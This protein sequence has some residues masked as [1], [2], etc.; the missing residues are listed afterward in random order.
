ME[1]MPVDTNS[2]E[3]WEWAIRNPSESGLTEK[4]IHAMRE[5]LDLSSPDY[6]RKVLK[7]P[8]KYGFA[9]AHATELAK[10]F[11]KPRR[12]TNYSS[13]D[14]YWF[15]LQCKSDDKKKELEK[16]ELMPEPLPSEALAKAHHLSVLRGEL[17]ELEAQLCGPYQAPPVADTAPEQPAPVEAASD[18]A[19]I[20]NWKMKIQTE[21]T[22]HC[23]R[24]RQSGA[25]PTKKSIVDSMANWC[26]KNDV[27]TDSKIFP[28]G[29]YLRT[30]VLGGK[31]WDLPN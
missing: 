7:N 23:L 24:L 29:N 26:R 25:S 11:T 13:E 15:D 4:G 30:H 2:R 1:K 22:A 16:W 17:A 10:H 20:P 27:K 3:Y 6:W 21:A 28:S 31:H 14:A 9:E 12:V 5:S 8:D 19:A 18:G